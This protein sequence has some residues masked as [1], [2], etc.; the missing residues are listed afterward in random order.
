MRGNKEPYYQ[1]D[2]HTHR[3]ME[4]ATWV[5]TSKESGETTEHNHN[6]MSKI[7]QEGYIRYYNETFTGVPYHRDKLD[8]ENISTSS[9]GRRGCDISNR[10]S[11]TVTSVGYNQILPEYNINCYGHNYQCVKCRHPLEEIKEKGEKQTARKK[12]FCGNCLEFNE[13]Y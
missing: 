12:L 3:A 7:A 9:L 4:N 2:L 13:V 8:P 10:A 1:F 11:S 6:Q 5:L